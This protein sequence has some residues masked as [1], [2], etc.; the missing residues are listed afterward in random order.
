MPWCPNLDH[1]SGL[2]QPTGKF[3][4]G[5]A[6][7]D[8]RGITHDEAGHRGWPLSPSSVVIPVAFNLVAV[9]TRL[10]RYEGSS[11]LLLVPSWPYRRPLRH[12]WWWRRQNPPL[13][14][15]PSSRTSNA[16]V[17]SVCIKDRLERLAVVGFGR[18]SLSP[19][20]RQVGL[21][22]LWSVD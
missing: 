2:G 16:G 9:R 21:K 4:L 10:A 11:T 22:L 19:M 3:R 13:Q 5:S 17:D 6:I 7:G 15:D 8:Q 20:G 1:G 18:D 12:S 14:T